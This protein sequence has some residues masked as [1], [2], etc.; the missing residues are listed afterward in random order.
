MAS[1]SR[2]PVLRATLASA[3]ANFAHLKDNPHALANALSQ[4]TSRVFTPEKDGDLSTAEWY[5]KYIT[6]HPKEIMLLGQFIRQ[7]RGACNPQALLTKVMGDHLGLDLTLRQG[8]ASEPPEPGQK[9]TNDING[10][11]FNTLDLNG[12]STIYDSALNVYGR[13][14]KDTPTYMRYWDGTGWPDQTT[15]S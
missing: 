2:D 15:P 3:E 8:Q 14:L 5:V 9:E 11:I 10:H 7:R 4:Y 1:P 13:S 6:E 12:D